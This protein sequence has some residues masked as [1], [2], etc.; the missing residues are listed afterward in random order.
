MSRPRKN[1]PDHTRRHN[2]PAPSSEAI[3]AH[4]S[5]LLKPVVHE[6]L[7]YYCQLGLRQRILGLPLMVAAVLSLLWRQIPSVREL[8]RTLAREDLLWC[9]AVK[10]SQ[11]ALSTRFLEFPAS[12]FERVLWALVEELK[13]RWTHR[14]VRPLPASVAW[15]FQWFEH[16]WIVDGS[17]LEAL[18]RKLKSLQEQ[19]ITLAGKIYTIVDMASHLPVAIRFEE[20]PNAADRN[21]WEWLHSTLPK[22]GL[23]IFDRG[24]YDFTEFEALVK[25]GSAWI[26]RL[27]KS[28]Y[29]VQKTFSQSANLVDQLVLLG[30]KKGKTKQITVR[31]IQVRHGKSW[32]KYI[33]SVLEPG[34]LPPYV[35]TDLYCRR[36]PIETA[37]FLVKRLLNL[38]YIWTGSINGVKLLSLGDMAVL[39]C[40]A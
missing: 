2:M 12:M 22:G 16:I 15:T 29:Q 24:F 31:L 30:H 6:Q 27:K 25:A 13:Q 11:Q 33:T 35:V 9:R 20:N 8:S 36:C 5:D 26:T 34:D 39:C 32:Y 19:P 28:T 21:Q 1:N 40:V 14:V 18:F 4:L 10:V 23:L 38:A 3:E 17:T 7:K 37:F